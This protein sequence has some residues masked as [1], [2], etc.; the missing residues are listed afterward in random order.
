MAKKIAIA[1]KGGTGKTTVA[2]TLARL[3]ARRG[4]EVWAIDADS[5]PNLAVTLGLDESR[6]AELLPLPRTL[7]EETQDEEG[8]K[9]LE[10]RV[11]PREVAERFGAVGPDGVRLLLMGRVDHAGAG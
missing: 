3:I 5:N 6:L 9:K 7:L 4:K 1:G 11:P 10:L 2:G 8:K